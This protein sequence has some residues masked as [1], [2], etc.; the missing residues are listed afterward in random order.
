MYIYIYYTYALYEIL[1]RFFSDYELIDES[2]I[3]P[4]TQQESETGKTQ[5]QGSQ[6]GMTGPTKRV[7]GACI[8]RK[9]PRT[10][11][12]YAELNRK[13]DAVESTLRADKDMVQCVTNQLEPSHVSPKAV[14]LP[15]DN[16]SS[17]SSTSSEAIE[18]DERTSYKKDGVKQ[19]NNLCVVSP[20][21][22]HPAS[23]HG[24]K[25][26]DYEKMNPETMESR[27]GS[28]SGY[29]KLNKAT[30]EQQ[31]NCGV[32][33]GQGMIMHLEEGTALS[34]RHVV[35]SEKSGYEKL[36]PETMERCK[37]SGTSG[38]DKLNKATMEPQK[39]CGIHDYQGV[40]K[41]LDMQTAPSSRHVIISDMG[42]YEKLNPETMERYK[43]SGTSG[44]EK[45]NTATMEKRK[46]SNV[47]DDHGMSINRDEG[48]APSARHVTL[49][50]DSDYETSNPET[51]ECYQESGADGD[52]KLH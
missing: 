17:S 30:M 23:R 7:K 14:S 8:G 40:S 16:V 13:A 51:M 44:D 34:T 38:Y 19:E 37:K 15:L 33:A 10:P 35:I 52:D 24:K 39:S 26:D 42:D 43:R 48:T 20:H 32:F 2:R 45:L 9:L 3:E 22:A 21:S 49:S 4:K 47:H 41:Y 50:E 1:L 25:K 6:L 46:S 5:Q 31:E 18:F 12:E 11:D 29:E 27:K 28:T 36:N